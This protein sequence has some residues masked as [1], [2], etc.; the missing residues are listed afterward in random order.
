MKT[1]I[2]MQMPNANGQIVIVNNKTRTGKKQQ[3]NLTALGGHCIGTIK[4]EL[5]PRKL[6]QGFRALSEH[7]NAAPQTGT[8]QS[9]A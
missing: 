4:S 3:Q 5:G 7:E 8:L 1:Y 2:L 6:A 9:G